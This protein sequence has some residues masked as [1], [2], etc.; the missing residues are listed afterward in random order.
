MS[1]IYNAQFEKNARD[2][3]VVLFQT[4]LDFVQ[5]HA[6]DVTCFVTWGGLDYKSG[7]HLAKKPLWEEALA[8]SMPGHGMAGLWLRSQFPGGEAVEWSRN[9]GFMSVRRPG[10]IQECA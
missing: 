9:G 10:A 5:P 3:L 2:I 7:C 8:P 6:V 4:L 1:G